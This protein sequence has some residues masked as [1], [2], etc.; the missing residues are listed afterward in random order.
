MTKSKST[1]KALTGSIISLAV[2]VIM[3]I[4]TTFA[5]FTDTASTSVNKIQAGK[6]NVEL[7]M[8]D[9]DNWV[10]A[11]GK[12]LE[13]KKAA[14]AAEGEAVLWEPGCTYE[15]PELRVVNKGDLALKYKLQLTGIKGDAKLNDVIEWT[16][17]GLALDTEGHLLANA[18]SAALTISG[19]MDEN[20][21]NEYQGLSIDGI[22]ITVVA[23]QDTVEY[24]SNDNQYDKDAKYSKVINQAEFLEA[25]NNATDGE[26]IY[27]AAGNYGTIEMVH[28]Y[29]NN[30]K[31]INLVGEKG[32]SIGLWFGAGCAAVEGWT[33]EN[34]N[35]IGANY[36]LTLDCINK[37][38]TVKNCTFTG[39]R[40][41][42]A[43]TTGMTTNLTIVDCKFKDTA[44]D[45]AN[46]RSAVYISNNNGV[47]IKNCTFEN[48][49]FN[50]IQIGEMQGNVT[51]EGNNINGTHDRALRFT[52]AAA[53]AAVTLCVKNNIVA[54]AKDGDGEVL[55]ANSKNYTISL[56]GNTWDGIA[57]ADMVTTDGTNYV[58][59]LPN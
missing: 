28:A 13:F 14:G 34:I 21:G 24:D 20:A 7:Q 37:D 25:L 9:G 8:K 15:L 46:K 42:S 47:T 6:L 12:T 10:N 16:I 51:I 54:N 19:H 5:W 23:T 18:E 30:V 52:K 50:A 27:L 44:Y 55:K 40:F 35:F 38:V 32:T 29:H 49:G 31:N 53:N 26:T 58:V 2:C 4:G 41:S 43:Q 22:A 11:E 17:G 45:D 3:L 36:G 57:D 59:K 48:A 39:G 56:T 1:K 33:F